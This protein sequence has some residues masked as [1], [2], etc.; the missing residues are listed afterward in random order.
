MLILIVAI[1]LTIVFATKKDSGEAEVFID[2]KLYEYI[3]LSVDRDYTILDGDMTL[4]V[5]D[6]AISVSH[7][8]CKEQLCVHSSAISKNGGMIVCLPNKVMIKIVS[9]EV[10]V[11]V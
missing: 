6:G 8:N 11:I 7:S 10:D 9:K 2:G 3:D 4:S 1:V 5:K